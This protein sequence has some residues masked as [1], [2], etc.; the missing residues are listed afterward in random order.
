MGK[1]KGKWGDKERIKESK[2]ERKK[3]YYYTRIMMKK[4]EGEEAEEATM[5]RMSMTRLSC[6][7]SK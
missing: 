7:T 5:E 4:S 1:R 6:K 3:G 2:K